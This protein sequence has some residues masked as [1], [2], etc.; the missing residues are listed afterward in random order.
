MTRLSVIVTMAAV[1]RLVNRFSIRLQI[2][3]T[4][5]TQS[6]PSVEYNSSEDNY[7][8]H[9]MA[10]TEEIKQEIV[11]VTN[12][13]LACNYIKICQELQWTVEFSVRCD[14]RSVRTWICD[15]DSHHTM[16]LCNKH[17]DYYRRRCPYH[18]DKAI[19]WKARR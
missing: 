10:E 12:K 8:P 3:L 9:T 5:T 13:N 1:T 6:E 19:Y 4:D 18:C 16:L 17:V 14:P 2:P 15:D 11:L 7:L